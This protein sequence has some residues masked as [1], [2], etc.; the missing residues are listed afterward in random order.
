MIAVRGRLYS[1]VVAGN[2]F[3]LCY[4]LGGYHWLGTP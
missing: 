4:T 1:K 3:M 2:D